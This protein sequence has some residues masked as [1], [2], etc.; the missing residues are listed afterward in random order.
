MLGGEIGSVFEQ[1]M[2]HQED[3]RHGVHLTAY[4]SADE[5]PMDAARGLLQA[6]VSWAYDAFRKLGAPDFDPTRHIERFFDHFDEVLPPRG[7]YLLAHDAEG[8]AVGTGALR[9]LSEDSAEMKH[10]Y[11]RPEHRG[12]GLGQALVE[13][14]I[15]AARD[16]G[17]RVLVADTF[18]GNDPMIRLYR[19]IGFVDA[20]PYNSA[21]AITSPELIP[22]LR[23]FR[24]E[25]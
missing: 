14:R 3:I 20:E 7:A 18:R 12:S 15:S 10:L 5:V 23:F 11:V 24:M 16:L 22:H 6:H 13:A 8:E 4:R 1:K 2:K 19:R 17:L 25:L 9:R 21:F